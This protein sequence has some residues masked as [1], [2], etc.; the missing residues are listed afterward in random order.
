MWKRALSLHCCMRAHVQEV[1]KKLSLCQWVTSNDY[2]LFVHTHKNLCSLL[3]FIMWNPDV[4]FGCWWTFSAVHD[5]VV[6]LST[7]S[8]DRE[9]TPQGKTFCSFSL[10]SL[11]PPP[12][13]S[14]SVSSCPLTH[15]FAPSS[16][17]HLSYLH[18][19]LLLF[20]PCL[21]PSYHSGLLLEMRLSLV[22]GSQRA[23]R[24]WL[25]KVCPIPTL[26][27]VLP[28]LHTHPHA[29]TCT[30]ILICSQH[31]AAVKSNVR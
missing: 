29:H 4:L 6:G 18:P 7:L 30:F 25:Q 28:H 20:S 24:S 16:T 23:W 31:G 3:Y 26:T 5:T 12:S 9:T 10:P 11:D 8:A 14:L 13:L 2:A 19:Y 22:T 27:S 15:T 17:S 1:S 21:C